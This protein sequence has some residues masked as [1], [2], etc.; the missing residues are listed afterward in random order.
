MVASGRRADILRI[1]VI[2]R[3]QEPSGPYCVLQR[4]ESVPPVRSGEPARDHSGLGPAGLEATCLHSRFG[5]LP[6]TGV[7]PVLSLSLAATSQEL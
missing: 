3:L 2:H 1:D 6:N 5:V 7:P 4:S